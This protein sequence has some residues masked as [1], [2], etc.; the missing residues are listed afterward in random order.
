VNKN[1][2]KGFDACGDTAASRSDTSRGAACCAILSALSLLLATSG[3]SSGDSPVGPGAHTAAVADPAVKKQLFD[4]AIDNLNHL[5][6][7]HAED[8][9]GRIVEHLNESIDL[10]RQ[11]EWRVDP[12]VAS[13]PE[14]DRDL[15]PMRD[16]VTDKFLVFDCFYLQEAVTLRNIARDARGEQADELARATKLFEWVVRNIALMQ[17]GE[18]GAD[19]AGQPLEPNHLPY[20]SIFLGRGEVIDRAWVFVLLCRQLGLDAAVLALPGDSADA[21]P[22]AW[23]VGVLIGGELYVF[24]PQLGLPIPA[25]QGQGVAKL[26]ELAADDALLRRLDLDAE[27]PYPVTAAQLAGT[28]ALVEGSPGYLS[29]RMKLVESRLTGD[30]RIVLATQPSIV[31]EALRK[32]PGVREAQ[33]WRLP[34]ERLRYQASPDV[35]ASSKREM[36]AFQ[37][38]TMPKNYQEVVVELA[39]GRTL[40]LAGRY[41]GEVGE[42]SANRSYQRARVADADLAAAKLSADELVALRAAKQSASYWLALVAFE[43]GRFDSALEHLDKRVLA[44]PEGAGTANNPWREAGLYLK[45]RAHEALGQI[46]QSIAALEATSGLQRTGNLLR[47][48]WL[49]ERAAAKDA[50]TKS[51]K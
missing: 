12:L 10:S 18:L 40:H 24:D 30:R 42:E 37:V 25:A 9:L 19:S 33:L 48:R 44:S 26:A 1:P 31:A 45:A 6:Q 34:Y 35:T 15:Q 5:E 47:A 21:P 13:L 46:D 49:K 32:C 4:T 17:P 23:A 50:A 36:L 20:Q 8:M 43:R 22:R 41:A 27:H 39:R 51:D 16:L 3:C 2:P 28:I 29:R 7:F 11:V 14:S 38:E